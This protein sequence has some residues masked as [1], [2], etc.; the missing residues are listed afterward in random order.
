MCIRDSVFITVK[1]WK[2]G[3]GRGDYVAYKFPTENPASP[4]RKGDHMVKLVLGTH[5]DEVKVCLLYTSKADWDIAQRAF[6]EGKGTVRIFH[7]IAVF[8]PPNEIARAAQSAQAVWRSRE[9]EILS[10]IHI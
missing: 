10:L 1:G 2:S 8:A 5:G 9:F 7:Q 4:F 6:D 3:L